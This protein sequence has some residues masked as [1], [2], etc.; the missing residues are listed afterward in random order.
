[1]IQ[2]HPDKLWD[3]YGIS[4]NPNITWEIIQNHPEKPW[5]WY[6]ISQ[7]PNITC[8]I[9]RTNPEK[10]W[11]WYWISRNLNITWDIIQNH[12]EKSWNWDWISQN[13][14]TQ[15]KQEFI[16]EKRQ[17]YYKP[18]IECIFNKYNCTYDLVAGILQL[19]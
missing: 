3:W 15:A 9:I 14:M 5:N 18:I 17:A 8:D 7:N 19:I 1:M 13:P 10:S 12:S 6:G 2:N 4:E 16:R 11:D